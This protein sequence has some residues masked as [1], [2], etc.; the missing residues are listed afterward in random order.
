M[1]LRAR[2]CKLHL[3][4]LLERLVS[5]DMERVSFHRIPMMKLS[6]VSYM[7]N[8]ALSVFQSRND[9]QTLTSIEIV[10]AKLHKKRLPQFLGNRAKLILM[11]NFE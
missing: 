2:C 4:M 9:V 3:P 5:L 10:L 8:R 7:S 6:K 11:Y 1:H